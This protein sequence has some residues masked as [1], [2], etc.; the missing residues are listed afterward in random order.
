[1]S[2]RR[3]ARLFEAHCFIRDAASTVL[4]SLHRR[5]WRRERTMSA[6]MKANVIA[7]AVAAVVMLGLDA[8]WL[9]LTADSLYRPLIG[10][11]MLD[12]FRP[13]PAIAFYALYL[14]GVV[15]FAI[16]PAFVTGR[17][18][19][20]VIH[21]ALFGLFAYATYDLTNQAT[22]KIWSMTI[23]LAD[24]AWGS[25]LTA[26]SAASGYL[27]ASRWAKFRAL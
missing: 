18:K 4:E 22:L 5:R 3:A 26:A 2:F 27:A 7:Y 16:R 1:L 9:T 13:G 10:A 6:D 17:W 21:G 23:T 24:M 8:T 14:C 25:F 19:T 11:L 20:A 12:G 15:I